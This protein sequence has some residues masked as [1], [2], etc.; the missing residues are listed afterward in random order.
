MPDE[1]LSS[2]S[3]YVEK[4]MPD[5]SGYDFSDPLELSTFC[6]EYN[7]KLEELENPM[8]VAIVPVISYKTIPVR[9]TDLDNYLAAAVED[10]LAFQEVVKDYYQRLGTNEQI[11]FPNFTIPE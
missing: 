10:K 7:T 3:I 2:Q 11:D 8:R 5:I 9:A 6:N 1:Q 4:Y